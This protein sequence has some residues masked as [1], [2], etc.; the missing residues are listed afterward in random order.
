MSD[1][2]KVD[3]KDVK[4]IKEVN[5]EDDLLSD[6]FVTE[7]DTFDIEVKFYKKDGKLF[8]MGVDDEF[9]NAEKNIKSINITLKYPSQ[10]DCLN[11]NRIKLDMQKSDDIIDPRSVLQ[12]E[13]SRFVILARKW[14]IKEKLEES[15]ILKLN[16]KILKGI[17]Q[18]LRNKIEFDGII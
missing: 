6:I 14:S 13:Y 16:P 8:V 1:E 2:K 18:L 3:V 12:L 4:D 10:S 15:N 9:D 7:E 11:M 17:F 5:K